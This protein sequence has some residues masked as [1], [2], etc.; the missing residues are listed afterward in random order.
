MRGSV[1]LARD[2]E[3]L[4]EQWFFLAVPPEVRKTIAEPVEG[5]GGRGVLGSNRPLHGGDCLT[6][7]RLGLFVTGRQPVYLAEG[8]LR[9]ANRGATG[10]DPV[11]KV[12]GAAA[13]ALGA[14]Q[15]S[16]PKVSVGHRLAPDDDVGFVIPRDG[17]IV[18]LLGIF[19]GLAVMLGSDE[20]VVLGRLRAL[21]RCRRR[22]GQESG[23][24][25]CCHEPP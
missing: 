5:I 22:P 2:G 24:R 16:K 12:E 20:R 11:E 21:G 1:G 14:I 3:R 25:Q 15:P 8:H 18:D 4:T 10:R 6:Q 19:L 23:D 9:I 13:K 7:D 17:C